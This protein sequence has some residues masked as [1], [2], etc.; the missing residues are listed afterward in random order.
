MNDM[1]LVLGRKLCETCGEK[2]FEGRSEDEIPEGAVEPMLDPTVC[3]ACG[4]DAGQLELPTVADVPLCEVCQVKLYNRPFPAWVKVAAVVVLALAGLSLKRNW[5]F[6]QA[7]GQTKE[8][9]RALEADDSSRAY[10]LMSSAASR[11]PENP[12]LAQHVKDIKGRM[13][14]ER[15]RELAGKGKHAE[16][17]ALIQEVIRTIPEPPPWMMAWLYTCQGLDRIERDQFAEAVKLFRKARKKFPQLEGIEM[18][19]LQAE[20][21]VAFEAR[22]YDAFLR[23]AGQIRAKV[24]KQPMAVAMVASALACKYAVTG[25]GHYKTQ[26][27]RTLDEA[28]EL[29]GKDEPDFKE[30]EER[31]LFRLR[32]REIITKKEYERRFRPKPPA[33]SATRP[34]KPGSAPA[35]DQN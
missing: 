1:F 32:T 9:F 23:K 11:V 20:I 16:A 24:P 35:E 5:R 27:L 8:A 34:A 15:A 10:K 26:T 3:A 19:I 6:L 21:G 28:R 7:Y 18:L 17:A 33:E 30:Y 13:Q 29:G 14:L 12:V 31:I 2:L 4:D 25:M 22:D